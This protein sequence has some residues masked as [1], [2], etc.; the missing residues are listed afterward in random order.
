MKCEN[1]GE[2]QTFVVLSHNITRYIFFTTASVLL[3]TMKILH[4]PRKSS[5]CILDIT[6]EDLKSSYQVQEIVKRIK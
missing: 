2:I 1:M 6:L 3:T 5:F 4:K